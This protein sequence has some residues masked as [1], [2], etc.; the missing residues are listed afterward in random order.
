MAEN[1]TC[2]MEKDAAVVT[3]SNP[4]TGVFLSLRTNP[5]ADDGDDD[6]AEEHST[7]HGRPKSDIIPRSA[8]EKWFNANDQSISQLKQLQ[9]QADK[10]FE[11]AKFDWRNNIVDII[12]CLSEQMAGLRKLNSEIAESLYEEKRNMRT[13]VPEIHRSSWGETAISSIFSTK[14]FSLEIPNTEPSVGDIIF[15]RRNRWSNAAF[16]KESSDPLPLTTLPERIKINSKRLMSFFN[17]EFCNG[18]LDYDTT[19]PLKLLRPFKS[20]VYLEK[21]IRTRLTELE[22]ALKQ[23]QDDLEGGMQVL[24][25]STVEDN[26][27]KDAVEDP[28]SLDLFELTALIMDLRCLTQFMDE[29]LGPA[30]ASLAAAPEMVRF[31]D[32]W[33]LFAQGTLVYIRNSNAPQKIW[34]VVQRTGGRRYLGESRRTTDQTTGTWAPFVLDCFY[35]DFDG[36]KFI[37]VFNQVTINGFDGTQAIKSLPVLPFA[38]AEK[39]GFTDREYLMARGRQFFDCTKRFHHLDYT[40]RCH[41]L[42]PTGQKLTELV[43]EIPRSASFYSEHIDSDVIVDFARALEEIPWWRPMTGEH[44]FGDTDRAETEGG[45]GVENDEAWDKRFTDDFMEA[46]AQVWESWVKVGGGPADDDLLILPDRVF[47]FVLSTRRWACLQI[48]RGPNGTE[49]LRQ[50]EVKG[51]P[52]LKLRLPEGHKDMVQSLIHAHF[53]RQTSSGVHF[54]LLRNKGNGVTILLHG[55]PGVGK[56]ST[57]ECAA[58]STGRPLLPVT[59]GDLGLTASDVEER[60][61][62]IF[63]LAQDWKC[64]MLLDEADVF[65]TQRRAFDAERNALVSVFLRTLEYY[66]GIL[67][68]TTNRVGTFDEAFKSRIHMSLY[69]PSLDWP[70]THDIWS[71]HIDEA[72]RAGIIVNK[73]SLLQYAKGIF[74][75]QQL[76][77][78][79]PVW[80]GRQIRN[81][82]QSALALATYNS[83]TASKIELSTMYFE[84]VF[85][86]S[87]KF[88]NYIW[89]TQNMQ[90]D[91]ERNR[92]SMVRR[93]DFSYNP[94][95]GLYSQPPPQGTTFQPAYPQGGFLQSTSSPFGHQTTQK[96][97]G[98]GGGQTYMGNG[99]NLQASMQPMPNPLGQQLGQPFQQ[100][101]QLSSQST[102]QPQFHVLSNGSTNNSYGLQQSQQ[103]QQPSPQLTLQSQPQMP[104]NSGNSDNYTLQQVQ[105]PQQQPQQAQ[106][107]SQPGTMASLTQT[108]TSQSTL[109]TFSQPFGHS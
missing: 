86:L 79:G 37:P 72:V 108:T 26:F 96:M 55:V 53:A 97:G 4:T 81:A 12:H 48:G 54:D 71:G 14:Y 69:Y 61:K 51:D 18:A 39:E 66:E 21:N 25:K 34:K 87:D 57:A 2:T 73:E 29:T 19:N 59:C 102:L 95:G 80:N 56:T 58:I 107:L 101:Q 105:P 24:D 42:T 64:I 16:S 106:F 76:P 83:H 45:P 40:G 68:L 100:Q 35:V 103:Q 109:P 30:Q 15:M 8:V 44:D 28:S 89:S 62:E 17:H 9:D 99:Q 82:F 74:Q 36:T 67:F 11:V 90:D 41:Y 3:N 98:L 33:F 92:N 13:S 94:Y 20:L 85:E 47:A 65:L 50:R 32:L 60:L 75:R 22:T 49:Q 63:R 27:Y 7:P 38:V 10:A 46:Q 1:N 88:S 84:K 6:N 52:W 31:V 5:P 104:S 78:S 70:P 91:A 43:D 23:R 93:D 77:G